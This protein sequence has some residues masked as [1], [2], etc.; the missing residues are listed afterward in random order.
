MMLL[1]I[2]FFK[3]LL[4]N[5][6]K[7]MVL[8]IMLL[9]IFHKNLQAKLLEFFPINLLRFYIYGTYQSQTK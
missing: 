4:D 5:Y 9:K 3:V 6:F 8:Q 2:F 7:K 1:K